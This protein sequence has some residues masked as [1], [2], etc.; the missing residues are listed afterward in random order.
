MQLLYKLWVKVNLWH[1]KFRAEGKF[2]QEFGYKGV[3][4]YPPDLYAKAEALGLSRERAVE[5]IQQHNATY[6]ESLGDDYFH[7]LR[8]LLSLGEPEDVRI[9]LFCFS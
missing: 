3:V 5:M 8:A 9:H 6:R 1:T 2:L 4:D 7:Q